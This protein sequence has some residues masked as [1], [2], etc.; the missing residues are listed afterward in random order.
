MQGFGILSGSVVSLI[1]VSAF[2][3]KIETESILYLDFAWRIILGLG[4][5]PAIATIYLRCVPS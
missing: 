3:H 4:C 5:L 1:T 2:K